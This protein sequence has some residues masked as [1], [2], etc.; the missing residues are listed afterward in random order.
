[1]FLWIHFSSVF[2]RWL[3][4]NYSRITNFVRYQSRLDLP[5]RFY[6]KLPQLPSKLSNVS[7]PKLFPLIF[8]LYWYF[9][10]GCVSVDGFPCSN[11]FYTEG[12]A[13]LLH[14]YVLLFGRF[15]FS[16]FLHNAALLF[17]LPPLQVSS[18]KRSPLLPFNLFQYISA[19]WPTFQQ[20]KT[21]F[22]MNSLIRC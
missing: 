9:S 19:N 10:F 14:F 1:M 17:P 5:G 13:Q 12:W 7:E 2:L 18:S 6:P 16:E 21:D 20:K 3:Q 22:L 11:S 15:Y 8:T 4:T